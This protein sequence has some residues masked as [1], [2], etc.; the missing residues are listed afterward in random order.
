MSLA[1]LTSE[2]LDAPRLRHGFFTRAGGVDRYFGGAHF[3][4][5]WTAEDWGGFDTIMAE[6]IQEWI[7]GGC[8][9]A[10]VAL[11]DGGKIKQFEQT[12]GKVALGM[13]EECFDK[14]ANTAGGITSNDVMKYD[15]T[16]YYTDFD[17]EH[18]ITKKRINDALEDWA[19][20]KGYVFIKDHVYTA[21][22]ESK[23]GIKLSKK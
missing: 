14:W 22:G 10:P 5:D 4:K 9:M 16:K 20:M 1:P 12:H 19:K 13:M 21:A 6:S 7:L 18:R 15:Y 3:P 11:S 2:L 17:I 23:R 8:K